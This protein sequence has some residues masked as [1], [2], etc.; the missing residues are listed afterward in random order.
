M[1]VRWSSSGSGGE[2]GSGENSGK[3]QKRQGFVE[4]FLSNVQQGMKRNKEMQESLKG[5]REERERMQRSFV[6]QRWKEGAEESW[7]K[8][9]DGGRK[10]WEVVKEG[11]SKTKESLNKVM[12]HLIVKSTPCHPTIRQWLM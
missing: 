11:L 3:G 1:C 2:E 9:R 12:S 6:W 4:S 10:G 7:E 8:T 5:L